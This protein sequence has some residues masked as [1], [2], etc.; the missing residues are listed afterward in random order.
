MS[1]RL[2]LSLV[3]ALSLGLALPSLAE[4]VTCPCTAD[5]AI[6]HGPNEEDSSGGKTPRIKL[7]I[8]QEFGLFDFDLSA[9]KGRKVVAAE[10]YLFPFPE[11]ADFAGDRLTTLRWLQISTIS[12]PWV[13]GTQDKQYEPDPAGHG[14][15]FRQA[16]YRRDDWAWPGSSVAHVINGHSNSVQCVSELHPAENGYW[17]VR[18]DPQLLHVLLAGG[19]HGLS[20]IDA[21]G[22]WR[23]NPYVASRESKNQEPYLLVT[24]EA[25]DKTAPEA[26]AGAKVEPAPDYALAEHGALTITLTAPADA[27]AYAVSFDGKTVQPWQIARPAKPGTTQRLVI[28]DLPAD[29]EAA[30]ELAAVDAAGNRSK[31]VQLQGRTSKAASVPKLPEVPFKPQPGEPLQVGEHLRVWAFPEIDKVDPQTGQLLHSDKAENFEK[32]N[33]VWS[34]KDKLIRLA[35]ARGEIAGFQLALQTDGRKLEPILLVSNLVGP[36][37]ATIQARDMRLFRAWYVKAG[38]HWQPEYA[39]PVPASHPVAP[40][41]PVSALSYSVKVAAPDNAVPDQKLQALHVDIPVPK[42]APAGPYKGKITVGPGGLSSEAHEMTLTLVVYPA[43]IPD[44]LRFNPELNAYGA[45]APV[46]TDKFLDYH[47]VAHYNRCTLNILPYTQDAKVYED[48]VPKVEGKGADVRVTD[49]NP[50]DRAVGPLLDGSAFKGLPRDG[51]PVRCLYLPLFENW[52]LTL[53]DHYKPGV[54]FDL[55]GLEGAPATQQESFPGAAD[56]RTD[57]LAEEF[58]R[59]KE[60]H[61]LAAPPIDQAFSDAYAKGNASIARQWA[62]HFRQKGWT[63]SEAQIYLNNKYQY[64]G[65]WW[66]LD[67]PMEHMEFAALAYFSSNYHKGLAG[68]KATRL[69][70]RGDISRP[71]WMGDTLDG[72]MEVIYFN[73]GSIGESRLARHLTERMPTSVRIYGSCNDVS[74][75]NFESAAWCLSSFAAGADG[76]L[77]WQSLGN[78]ESLTKP[79]T[80]GLLAP[81]DRFGATAVASMRVLAMRHGAQQCELLRLLLER[82]GWTREHARLLIAQ[83]VPIRGQYRERFLDEAA[84]VRYARLDSASFLALKEGILQLL[85]EPQ[86]KSPDTQPNGAARP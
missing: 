60:A 17:K 55:S 19:G 76:V 75:S 46:G 78:A 44:E 49:W 53:A 3:I 59:R 21:S 65:T 20:V 11:K 69:V 25:E 47:R 27:V 71:E 5:V 56:R 22:T 31:V 15:T 12:S 54:I 42:D 36:G 79:D 35:A 4:Q 68:Q 8:H 18:V 45:P 86:N 14:A 82:N 13:E 57:T 28:Q 48:M 32:A 63:R 40:D 33:P 72:L 64:G 2:S 7:K 37:D 6:S 77:P 10:L 16:S 58:A 34:G 80:L 29:K 73:S 81:G 85:A 52:P 70:F 50:Y 41:R 66:L 9:L 84:A 43:V 67:E 30:I 24:V 83:R 39:I 23:A 38:D 1:T 26:P 62:E 74:R 51:V 61:D